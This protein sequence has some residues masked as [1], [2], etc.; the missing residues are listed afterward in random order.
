VVVD[1]GSD[2]ANW[3]ELD[4]GI[5]EAFPDSVRLAEGDANAARV[6]TGQL[7]VVR[8]DRNLG[9]SGGNNVGL[10]IAL[11]SGTDWVFLLN[12]DCEVE[13]DLVDGMVSSAARMKDVGAIGC[14][15]LT[16]D[17]PPRVI[18]G[19]GKRL[20]GLGAHWLTRWRKTSGWWPVNFVPFACVALSS[21]ALLQIGLLDERY[22][23]YVE[24]TEFCHRLAKHGWTMRINL[25]VRVK[26]RVSASLGR[27]SPHYYYYVTRNTPLFIR[28]QLTVA[29]GLFSITC[30][31]AQSLV[32]VMLLA[33]S[34][35]L[36]EARAV[37]VGWMDHLLRRTGRMP[38]EI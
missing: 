38:S 20:Y 30:F 28:E 25:D 36:A 22:F 13:A 12:N 33:S 17:D 7:A 32:L 4:E 14:Q 23:A 15:L 27:R 31:I 35:R 18:Y 19:G 34:G 9:Y 10:R 29:L 26:H 8:L 5:D 6:N 21:Q 37:F 24:D 1:N 2:E 16:F 3:T 11:N